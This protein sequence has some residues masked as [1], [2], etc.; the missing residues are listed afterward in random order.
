MLC[1]DCQTKLHC[2]KCQKAYELNYWSM[3]ERKNYMNRESTLVCKG[4]R[5]QGFLP[6][7]LTTYT[8]QR[9]RCDLGA[10]KFDNSRIQNHKYHEYERLECTEC[11]TATTKRVRQLRKSLQRSNR[12][13]RCQCRIHQSKCPLTPVIFGEKRWPGS[14]GAISADDRKFLDELNPQPRWWAKAWGR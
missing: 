3:S 6:R 9:C 8:C 10:G 2:G 7:D 1:R 14:D 4:C 5:A 12:I 13:C 11:T